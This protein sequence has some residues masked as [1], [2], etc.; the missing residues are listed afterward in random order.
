MV[1]T[2]SDTEAAYMCTVNVYTVLSFYTSISGNLRLVEDFWRTIEHFLLCRVEIKHTLGLDE[3]CQR[4]LC[5]IDGKNA[6]CN[7]HS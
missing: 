7:G 4:H 5:C 3:R 6:M 1:G 2:K